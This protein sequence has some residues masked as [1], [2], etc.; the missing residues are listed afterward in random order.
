M[1]NKRNYELTEK[2]K[3]ERQERENN[4]NLESIANSSKESIEYLKEMLEVQKRTCEL[5]EEKNLTLEE[6][7]TR[8]GGG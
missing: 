3:K 6:Y 1:E 2:Q 7:L 4:Y 8:Y 5:L